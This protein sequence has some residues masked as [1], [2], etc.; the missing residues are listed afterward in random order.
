ML[1]ASHNLTGSVGSPVR[2]WSSL[3]RAVRRQTHSFTQCGRLAATKR[4]RDGLLRLGPY[5][6]GGTM[7]DEDL[8]RPAKQSSRLPGFGLSHILR[9]LS[10]ANLQITAKV[11]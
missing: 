10:T 7:R 6:F 5:P 1:T 4:A 8:S 3:T 9:L 2:P 11:A